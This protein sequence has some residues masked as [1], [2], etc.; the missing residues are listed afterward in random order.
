M[1]LPFVYYDFLFMFSEDSLKLLNKYKF[2]L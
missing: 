1:F 2:N